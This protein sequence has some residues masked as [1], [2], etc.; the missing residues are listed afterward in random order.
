MWSLLVATLSGSPRMAISQPFSQSTVYCLLWVTSCMLISRE[1]FEHLPPNFGVQS[2][3]VHLS[4]HF[5][6]RGQMIRCDSSPSELRMIMKFEFRETLINLPTSTSPHELRI[7]RFCGLY[8]TYRTPCSCLFH[9]QPVL[10]FWVRNQKI[11]NFSKRVRD[12]LACLGSWQREFQ[13]VVCERMRLFAGR[14]MKCVRQCGG[15]PG[16]M[17]PLPYIIAHSIPGAHHHRQECHVINH[18]THFS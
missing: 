12:A 18:E 1:S 16:T 13:S 2:L 11:S 14:I 4:S 5:P 6:I 10:N 15:R 17:W 9:A 7:T 3:I 8:T